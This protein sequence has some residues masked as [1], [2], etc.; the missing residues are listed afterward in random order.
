MFPNVIEDEHHMGLGLI[1]FKAFSYFQKQTHFFQ[2]KCHMVHFN[3]GL[4]PA[5][6]PLLAKCLPL[7]ERHPGPN[8]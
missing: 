1:S 2:M 6:P 4:A 5:P 7:Y 8:S 3:N